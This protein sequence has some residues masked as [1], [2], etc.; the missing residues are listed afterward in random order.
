LQE[1]KCTTNKKDRIKINK[2]VQYSKGD[3]ILYMMWRY[4][5]PFIH[6]CHGT[7]RLYSVSLH[8]SSDNAFSENMWTTELPEILNL[9]PW[10]WK[11]DGEFVIHNKNEWKLNG[12]FAYVAYKCVFPH[13]NNMTLWQISFDRENLVQRRAI[14]VSP[15][16]GVVIQHLV[17][18]RPLSS[19]SK[20]NVHNIR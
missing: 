17:S 14:L 5:L 2:C 1:N 3:Y 9:C 12:C 18:D 13:S 11:Y 8:K 6:Q 10:K 19:I 7:V 15:Q 20:E 4:L 16:C